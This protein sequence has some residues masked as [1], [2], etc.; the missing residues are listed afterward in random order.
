MKNTGI[1]KIRVLLK[2]LAFTGILPGLLSCTE[3]LDWD[4]KYQETSQIVVEGRI[5][6]EAGPPIGGPNQG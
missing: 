6:N 1:Y 2:F 3:E 4:L 5:T